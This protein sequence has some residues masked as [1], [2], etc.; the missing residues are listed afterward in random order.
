MANE[1]P[2]DSDIA[3]LSAYAYAIARLMGSTYLNAA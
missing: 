1:R 3:L 2:C